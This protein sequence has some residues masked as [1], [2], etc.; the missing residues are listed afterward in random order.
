MSDKRFVCEGFDINLKH[1]V[2]ECGEVLSAA[3]KTLRFGPMSY[4]PDHPPEE[5]EP[6]CRWLHR[7]L[8]DLQDT[9][10]RLKA[11]MREEGFIR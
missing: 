1:L 8:E 2:E 6:N 5:R 3:G 11:A 9:I 4:N 7:E 10:S